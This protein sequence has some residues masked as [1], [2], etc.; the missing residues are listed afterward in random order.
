MPPRQKMVTLLLLWHFSISSIAS[1]V[2]PK[3]VSLMLRTRPAAELERNGTTMRC[4][5]ASLRYAAYADCTEHSGSILSLIVVN[6]M[7]TPSASCKPTLPS[8]AN[9]ESEFT[10]A[11]ARQK[12]MLVAPHQFTPSRTAEGQQR[13]HTANWTATQLPAQHSTAQHVRAQLLTPLQHACVV[14]ATSSAHSSKHLN[15]RAHSAVP[16]DAGQLDTSRMSRNNYQ[17]SSA[18]SKH[19]PA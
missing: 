6:A 10:P 14:T 7:Q 15:T 13:L 18:Q 1:F 11:C 3:L 8:P 2:V 17:S 5:C 4:A 9:P 19:L 12:S 16:V